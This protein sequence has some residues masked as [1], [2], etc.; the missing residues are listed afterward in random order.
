L[1]HQEWQLGLLNPGSCDF[2]FFVRLWS[3]F[4][5]EHEVEIREIFFRP[6]KAFDC[7]FDGLVEVQLHVLSEHRQ[8]QE[9]LEK[10]S[11]ELPSDKEERSTSYR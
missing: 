3:R 8:E 4:A 6:F 9:W 5:R 1:F 7:L 11:K 10:I 2:F